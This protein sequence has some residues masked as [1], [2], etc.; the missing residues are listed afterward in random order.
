M[1]ARPGRYKKLKQQSCENNSNRLRTHVDP[2]EGISRLVSE[3]NN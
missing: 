1:L 2:F 3:N